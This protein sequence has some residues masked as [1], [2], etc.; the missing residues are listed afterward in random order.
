M[1]ASKNKKKLKI[2]LMDFYPFL[3][4]KMNAIVINLVIADPLSI[5][6]LFLLILYDVCMPAIVDNTNIV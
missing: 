6:L 3:V 2:V 1:Y 4:G 5:P